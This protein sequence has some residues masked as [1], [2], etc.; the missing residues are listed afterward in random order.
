M[1]GIPPAGFNSAQL[2]AGVAPPP[3][4]PPVDLI[5]SSANNMPRPR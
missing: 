2:L 5:G 4:Y 3:R 1:M